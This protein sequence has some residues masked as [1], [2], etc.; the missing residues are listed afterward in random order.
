MLGVVA[1]ATSWCHPGRMRPLAPALIFMLALAP[2]AAAEES[3][4]AE[5][6]R[7]LDE[8]GGAAFT[9]DGKVLAV[10]G[11]SKI[12]LRDA[13]GKDVKA[14]LVGG[15]G[16]AAFAFTR[17]GTK[18]LSAWDEDKKVFVH[19]VKTKKLEAKL[20]YP[21][22]PMS[23]VVFAPDGKCLAFVAGEAKKT[24]K[25]WDPKARRMKATLEGHTNT[26]TSIA[27]SPDGKTIATGC[28][29]TKGRL[30]DAE[31]GEL[32]ATLEGHQN[33]VQTV[34]FT[35]SG[36]L[37]ATGGW[38]YD[39]LMWDVATR[40]LTAKLTLPNGATAIAFTADGLL[41]TARSSWITLYDLATG[42]TL[43]RFGE[44]ADI[45][46]LAWSADGKTL[47]SVDRSGKL[48]LWTIKLRTAGARL[49]AS[50]HAPS[51][52]AAFSPDGKTIVSC[53]VLERTVKIRDGATGEVVA[54][55]EGHDAPV[56][57]VAWSPDGK[58]I[59][60]GADDANVTI[61]AAAER[62]EAVSFDAGVKV[63]SVAF[64]PDGKTLAVGG[65]KESLGLFAV[66]TG[67]LAAKLS[68]SQ[69]EVRSLAFSPDGKTLAVAVGKVVELWDTAKNERRATLTDHKSEVW[70]VVF[71]PDGKT[72][73]TGSWDGTVK[74]R[75]A[76]GK[77]LRTLDRLKEIYSVAFAPDGKTLATGNIDATIALFSSE[78]GELRG[79]F[80]GHSQAQSIQGLAFPPD[81]KTLLSVGSGDALKLWI[82]G[83]EK[84]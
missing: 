34:A 37:V 22:E 65:K 68:P 42:Q 49:R 3:R 11:E 52:S 45:R 82:V 58:L 63:L 5:T 57:T 26:V 76:S 12:E 70:C 73:A 13:D 21:A 33:S 47:L 19:D 7:T 48:T 67:K 17:D 77:V 75:D 62:K 61:W 40:K 24:V 64:S 6:K 56:A 9:P 60:S 69:G 59:A 14:K 31:T 8:V 50:V 23:S 53:E 46:S 79:M 28:D 55:L 4:L 10:A 81:G 83:D 43:G 44:G 32:L 35:P 72:L 16:L 29:D 27:F 36:K 80:V 74:L 25:V 66:E 71:S 20:D 30:F 18:L 39:I 41:A 1:R 15:R 38:D 51:R 84:R 2:L 54:T 78:T